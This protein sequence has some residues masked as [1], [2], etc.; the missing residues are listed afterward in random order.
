MKKYRKVKIRKKLRELFSKPPVA[1]MRPKKS[2]YQK[3]SPIPSPR[4]R[5]SVLSPTHVFHIDMYK[6]QGKGNDEK[7]R[8]AKKY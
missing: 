3:M 1:L 7:I 5:N 2:F 4:P 6:F 8:F